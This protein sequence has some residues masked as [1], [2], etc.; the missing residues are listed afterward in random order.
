MRQLVGRTGTLLV[1]TLSAAVPAAAQEHRGLVF[2]QVGRAS[3]GHADSEQGKA[4]IVGGGVSFNLTPH[5]AVE[6]DVHTARV[7]HVFG[8]EDHD[9]SQTTFTGSLLYRTPVGG[10]VRFLAGGGLGIQRAHIQFDEPGIPRVDTVETLRLLHGRAGAEWDVAERVAIRTEGVLWMG[11]GLDWVAGG[12][13]VV[14][15]RF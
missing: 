6:G 9:F 3:I 14:G 13:V 7:S 8:R 11:G 2:G 10:N 5:L 1:L 15:Y 12:R 4:P